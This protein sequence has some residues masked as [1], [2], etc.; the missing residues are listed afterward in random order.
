MAIEYHGVP[1]EAEVGA[2][3]V[4]ESG[5]REVPVK[6]TA[7]PEYAKAKTQYQPFKW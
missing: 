4:S 3:T 2:E 1:I 5:E 6:L 7:K